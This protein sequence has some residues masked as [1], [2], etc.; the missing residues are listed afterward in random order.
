MQ[1]DAATTKNSCFLCTEKVKIAYLH[2]VGHSGKMQLFTVIYAPASV[3]LLKS[4]FVQHLASFMAEFS[5]MAMMNSGSGEYIH[6]L[7]LHPVLCYMF[8]S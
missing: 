7:A 2:V 1:E 4:N 6:F 5:T 8:S 3:V